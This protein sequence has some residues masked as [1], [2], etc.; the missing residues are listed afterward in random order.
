MN[1]LLAEI[2]EARENR[3]ARQQALLRQYHCAVVCF[4]MNIAG[5]VKT[6]PLIRR[7]FDAGL[8]A[9]EDTLRGYPV[10]SREVIHE[11]TGDEAVFSVDMDAGV[12]K[13]RCTSIEEASPMGRLFDMDVLDK[14]G[15]KLERGQERSC[16]VCGAP[17]RSCA[18][19][20][21][22]SVQ[23]LQEA[24]RKRITAYFDEA[25]AAYIASA[26]V[27]ALIDEVQTTPKPGLVD[28]RNNGS[29]ADMN[30]ALFAASAQALR[31]YFTSCARIAQETA[32]VSPQNVFPLLREAGLKAEQAMYA[33]TNGVNT[34]KGAI[35]TLG[36]LCAAFARMWHMGETSPTVEDA[37]SLCAAIAGAAA[38]ADLENAAADTAGLQLYREMN[39]SGIRGEMA[40][41]LPSV[42]TVGLPA[43]R[44][45]RSQGYSFHDAGA[46]AL[47]HLIAH[48]QDTNLYHRGGQRG[49]AFAAHGAQEL[50]SRS[51]YPSREQ[52]E[53]LDDAFI[54]RNLSPGGCA[55]LLAAT[56]LMDKLLEAHQ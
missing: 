44:A 37:A 9:L 39:I 17:G 18:A 13:A 20:R 29:H 34:H 12:L 49:A 4:T 50:L 8:C 31:P 7:A 32:A 1:I 28:Q 38:K 24:T 5:P 25:D 54:A 47:L 2:L 40:Q 43:F 14:N 53:A 46:A 48:V 52:I 6:S 27:E 36:I 19:G 21:L 22:H 3:A 35:Y 15:Q 56:Y 10:R 11:I 23:E 51:P 55:D 42:T 33:A 30:P 26:A 16:L 45:A 41:G